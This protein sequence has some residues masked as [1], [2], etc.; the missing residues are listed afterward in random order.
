MYPEFT[1]QASATSATSVCIWESTTYGYLDYNLASEAVFIEGQGTGDATLFITFNNGGSPKA[2]KY[3]FTDSIGAHYFTLS[4]EYDLATA[5]FDVAYGSV[6]VSGSK[7]TALGSDGAEKI[8][9]INS[10][11]SATYDFTSYN[12]GINLNSPR[13][14]SSNDTLLYISNTGDNTIITVNPITENQTSSISQANN[15]TFNNP[16]RIRYSGESYGKVFVTDNGNDRIVV[17][18][19]PSPANPYSITANSPYDVAFTNSFIM[20]LS[21]TNSNI[22][23][24]NPQNQQEL[25]T[26]GSPGT[27]AGQF[28]GPVSIFCTGK[29]LFI[30]ESNRLQ[31]IRSGENDWLRP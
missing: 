13:S 25:M 11:S 8:L 31:L 9:R 23:L 12:A 27:G 7:I 26:F 2:S 19:D 5:S 16:L 15:I 17:Y 3:S 1:D 20:S 22:T 28:N 29:D 14:I 24:Y 21:Q 10:I 6:P 30:L 18:E 4:E